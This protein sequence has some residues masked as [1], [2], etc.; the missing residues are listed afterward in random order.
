MGS[1]RLF[2]TNEKG[3]KVMVASVADGEL[4]IHDPQLYES[5]TAPEDFN[6]GDKGEQVID[7]ALIDRLSNSI[8]DPKRATDARAALEKCKGMTWSNALAAHSSLI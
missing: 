1:Y 2:G 4:S 5:I 8:D 7:T 6:S 3:E